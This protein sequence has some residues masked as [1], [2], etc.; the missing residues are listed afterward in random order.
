MAFKK[1]K[2]I[3]EVL[4]NYDLSYQR[5]DFI[6]FDNFTPVSQILQDEITFVNQKIIT[7]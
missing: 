3:G 6:H 4:T 1:F 5:Q 7:Q 2:E